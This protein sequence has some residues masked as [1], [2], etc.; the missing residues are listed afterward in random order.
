VN[1]PFAVR[2]PLERAY[3]RRALFAVE[4]LD[5]VTLERVSE[6][7]TVTAEGLHGKPVRNSS[8]LFVWRRE[9]LGP[10]TRIT[11]DPGVRPYQ[12]VERLKSELLL[13]PA[14]RPIT[15]IELPPRADYQFAPGITAVRGTLLEDR[16]T[17][18]Q[19]VFDAVVH[20]RWLDVDGDW[21]DA[22]TAARTDDRGDFV[23]V[24]RLAPAEV[25]QL[26]DGKTVAVRLQARR[27]SAVRQSIDV[28]LPQGRVADSTTLS[29]LTFAWNEMQP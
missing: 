10:L 14:P 7:V 16:G 4:L 22:P 23:G 8:G 28:S 17:P 2:L 25:P 29:A 5:A 24:L 18:P 15:P 3:L 12:A 9:D 19:P 26:G 27:S 6:G 21:R 13:P 20:L 11:V 1:R